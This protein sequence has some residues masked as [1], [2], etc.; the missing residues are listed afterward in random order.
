M[1]I[2]AIPAAELEAGCRV[3]R[4]AIQHLFRQ[5]GVKEDFERWKR[6]RDKK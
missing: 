2:S 1:D 3:L 6:E 5:P 4:E